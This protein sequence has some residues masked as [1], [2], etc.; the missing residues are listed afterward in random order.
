MLK[1]F[2]LAS[3]TQLAFSLA[4]CQSNL[5]YLVVIIINYKCSIYSKVDLIRILSS[6]V[7]LQSTKTC[8]V[9]LCEVKGSCKFSLL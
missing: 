4:Y 8:S 1:L 3:N 5:S 2:S 9:Y 7:N 6:G